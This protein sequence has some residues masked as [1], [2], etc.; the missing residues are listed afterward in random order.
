MEGVLRD[1]NQHLDDIVAQ[2]W[3]LLRDCY[4]SDRCFKAVLVYPRT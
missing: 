4:P 3:P 1:I 2:E